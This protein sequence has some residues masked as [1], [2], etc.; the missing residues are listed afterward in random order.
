MWI[1]QFLAI[2]EYR[3]SSHYVNFN[4]D[5]R[6]AIIFTVSSQFESCTKFIGK[7][8]KYIQ[9]KI[10][11]YKIILSHICKKDIGADRST[12]TLN[13]KLIRAIWA[14]IKQN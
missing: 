4:N 5:N 6:W 10:D 13:L 1:F 7:Q 3:T 2:S 8:H 9:H 12:K 11:S 14:I